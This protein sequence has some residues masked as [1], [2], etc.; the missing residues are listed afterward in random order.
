MPKIHIHILQADGFS[1]QQF[2]I[3]TTTI[4]DLYAKA[5]LKIWRISTRA[6]PI[7]QRSSRRFCES[8]TYVGPLFAFVL[9][10]LR[11]KSIN[12]AT[13]AMKAYRSA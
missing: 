1:S 10:F 11:K 7:R 13:N 4:A 5:V 3:Y 8:A 6:L 9:G 2:T 12:N